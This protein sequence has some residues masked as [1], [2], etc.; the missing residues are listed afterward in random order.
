MFENKFDYSFLFDHGSV[1]AK[2][3]TGGLDASS[4]NVGC[5]GPQSKIHDTIIKQEDGYLGPSHDP[6]NPLMVRV[7][8]IQNM[9]FADK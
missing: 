9:M 5:G 1:H 8:G 7:G 3:N 6:E 2:K 4:M